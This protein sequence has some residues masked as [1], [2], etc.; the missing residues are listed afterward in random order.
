MTVF[1]RQ[2]S[3]SAGHHADTVRLT[4]DGKIALSP[5]SELD[6][7]PPPS[8]ARRRN[9]PQQQ[10]HHKAPLR[11]RI[12]SADLGALGVNLKSPV[13]ARTLTRESSHSIED[14]QPSPGDSNDE[15]GVLLDETDKKRFRERF[16]TLSL[17]NWL[18]YPLRAL[19]KP[20]KKCLSRFAQDTAD[21]VFKSS[22][23]R[24]PS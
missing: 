17:K 10:H 2:R 5:V 11:K 15:T 13:R 6:Q 24:S 22:S 7:A 4:R 1:T 12:T 19:Y 14:P 9:S 21:D 23:T 20:I 18:Y 16:R 8:P 3:F